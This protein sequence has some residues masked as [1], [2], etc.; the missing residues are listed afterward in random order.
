MVAGQEIKRSTAQVQAALAD[1]VAQRLVLKRQ[2]SNGRTYY[3]LNRRK[4]P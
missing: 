4:G 2:G 1:L 3:R